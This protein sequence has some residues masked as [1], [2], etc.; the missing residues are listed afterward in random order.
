MLDLVIIAT[1]CASLA[2]FHI[3]FQEYLSY[4]NVENSKIQE[5]DLEPAHRT[6]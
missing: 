4:T 3:N 6:I 5:V 1:T 2:T